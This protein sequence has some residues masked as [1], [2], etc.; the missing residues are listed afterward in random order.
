MS[1]FEP[2]VTTVLASYVAKINKQKGTKHTPESIAKATGIG[3]KTMKNIFNN[4]STSIHFN[5]MTRLMEYFHCKETDI[6]KYIK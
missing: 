4:V 1:K 2:K 5:T 6:I 3:V